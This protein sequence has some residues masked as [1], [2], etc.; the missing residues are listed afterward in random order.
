MVWI[1][2]RPKRLAISFLCSWT[3]L[4]ASRLGS[5]WR[6]PTNK[7]KQLKAALAAYRTSSCKNRVSEPAICNSL[8]FPSSFSLSL[9]GFLATNSPPLRCN[10]HKEK[11]YKEGPSFDET[12]LLLYRL[13]ISI[14]TSRLI[15]SLPRFPLVHVETWV[16]WPNYSYWLP[17]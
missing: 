3:F 8:F 14:G 17:I 12:W 11:W 9:F 13:A 16:C 6:R 1:S 15:S 7:T 2:G 10:R 5:R 4:V